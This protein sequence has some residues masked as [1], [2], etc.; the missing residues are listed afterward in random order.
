MPKLQK[1]PE[2]SAFLV[3][4]AH[5]SF[6]TGLSALS[7]CV[8]VGGRGGCQEKFINPDSLVW[9]SSFYVFN[10]GLTPKIMKFQDGKG[11]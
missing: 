1:T 3:C 8:C 6:C 7:K 9:N 11:C 2:Y 4:F 10:K 5:F